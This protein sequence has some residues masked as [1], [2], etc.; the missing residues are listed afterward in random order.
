M[1]LQLTLDG[2]KCWCQLAM[3]IGWSATEVGRCSSILGKI[4]DID[5]SLRRLEQMREAGAKPSGQALTPVFPVEQ[6]GILRLT[7]E[8]VDGVLRAYRR[9]FSIARLVDP[10]ICMQL[11][12]SE[13]G[14]QVGRSEHCYTVWGKSQRCGRC[15]SQTVVQTRQPQSK[16]ETIGSEVYYVVASYLEVDGVPYSLELVNQIH[17][18]DLL[19]G[20][21]RENVLSQLLLRN[22]QVYTDSV[23]R[24]YNRRYYDERLRQMKGA[25][26]IAMIDLDNFKQINDR[27]G[28][29]AG[30]AVLYQAAQAIK[31]EIRSNDDLVRYGGDEF[32]LLF[33]DM[34]PQSLEG[35]LQAIRRAL[36]RIEFPEY[37]GMR[38]SASIGGAYAEGEIA[39]TIRKADQA[40][41][42][43][44][45]KKDCVALY[46]EKENAHEDSEVFSD[47][48]R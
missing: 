23:T 20:S 9:M 44:K 47:R 2:K 15:I 13:S 5:G 41:Y 6:D 19:E 35:K 29:L 1:E 16:I 42:Q 34:P 39:Q 36:A 32:F 33:R 24:V 45:E 43:A 18:S 46:H 22:R 27:F 7:H 4:R 3:M 17:H 12:D 26:A 11:S 28:H 48:R 37:P 8:Q 21:D 14:Q 40:M 31:S 25:F 10:S 38:I 30:D